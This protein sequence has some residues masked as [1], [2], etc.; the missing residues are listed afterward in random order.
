MLN[1]TGETVPVQLEESGTD[2]L[3]GRRYGAGDVIS[4]KEADVSII[5]MKP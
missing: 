4:I 3:T 2:I 5:R 1:H